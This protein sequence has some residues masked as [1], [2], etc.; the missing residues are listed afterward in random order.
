MTNPK[1][2][3]VMTV[4]NGEKYIKESIEC[5]LNQTFQD[6]ELLVI[7]DGSTDGSV[8]IVES[9]QDSR[10]RLIHNEKNSGVLFTRNRGLQEAFGEYVAVLDSDDLCTSNRLETQY[11]FLEANPDIAVCGT[12]GI[13]IDENGTVFGHK[14]MPETN[15]NLVSIAMLF[16]NQFIHSSVMYRK[17]IALQAGGYTTVNGGLAEDFGLF[18]RI[19][20]HH[21]M[22]NIPE[23]ITQYR[24]HNLGISKTK[25]DG[26]LV[27]ELDILAYLYQ[28]FGLS[29]DELAVPF[30]F[31]QNSFDA[32][33]DSQIS[34]F[35]NRIL[36]QNKINNI[37]PA[38]H[39]N[40]VIFSK[41]YLIVKQTKNRFLAKELYQ[42]SK[43]FNHKLT[44]REKKKLFKLH[45]F[46]STI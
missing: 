7:N 44:F 45:F 41:W 11:N 31:I 26:I 2:T 38:K 46:N 39:F 19:S 3:V 43:K 9:F 42:T 37:Y 10:I 20:I 12:W 29:K 25:K 28:R 32:L 5:V 33:S 14:I 23:Y 1:I 4:Y 36:E 27:G 35:F 22:A 15:K 34:T 13:M 6:F 24:E 30:S 8:S 18:S 17:E 16:N 40:E 21:K